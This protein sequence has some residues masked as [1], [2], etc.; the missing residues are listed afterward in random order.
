MKAYHFQNADGRADILR[1][2]LRHQPLEKNINY[3]IVAEYASDLSGS[4]LKE[5]CRLAVLSRV[6]DAFIKGADL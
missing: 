4:D 3:G 5:V 2:L 6:K 1:V